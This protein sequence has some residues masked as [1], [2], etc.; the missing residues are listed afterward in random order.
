MIIYLR[1]YVREE[2]GFIPG[3]IIS[4]RAL[5]DSRSS[6]LEQWTHEWTDAVARPISNLPCT[7][8]SE[9]QFDC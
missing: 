3:G 6:K 4:L 1:N 8:A 5:A 7:L 9:H 2:E